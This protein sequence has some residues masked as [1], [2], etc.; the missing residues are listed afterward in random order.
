M[1][2]NSEVYQSYLLRLWRDKRDGEWRASLSDVGTGE[3][4]HFPSI[5]SLFAYLCK[6]LGLSILREIDRSEVERQRAS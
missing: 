5:I 4:R 6:Q 3:L 1:R 2:A